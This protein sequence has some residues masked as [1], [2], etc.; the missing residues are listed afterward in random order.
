MVSYKSQEYID[1]SSSDSEKGFEPPRG[2][3][4][5]KFESSV[6]FPEEKEVW[7]IRAP[8]GLSLA[9]LKSLPVSFTATSIS[10][11]AE[12]FSVGNK[13]YQVN[14]DFLTNETDNCKYSIISY[15]DGQ[16]RAGKRKISRF[17]SIREDVSIPEIDYSREI[18]PRKNVK[19]VKNLRMRHFPT[20]YGANDFLESDP[21]YFQSLH[22]DESQSED[23]HDLNAGTT[24]DEEGKVIKKSK[25]ASTSKQKKDKKEKKETK[26]KKD[27]KDKK[28]KKHKKDKK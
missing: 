2:F 7:L 12:P 16:F 4:S 24:R 25:L 23:E 9:E 13:S 3:Q 18:K 8:K 5:V 26:E 1:E 28:E 10:E 27:K 19:K 21:K 20:A 6:D 14:E 11:S 17:Y 15:Q 22:E